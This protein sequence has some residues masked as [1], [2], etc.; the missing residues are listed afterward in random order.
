[1]LGALRTILLLASLCLTSC[2][3]AKRAETEQIEQQAIQPRADQVLFFERPLTLAA[4]RKSD[5]PSPLVVLLD[6]DP[7]AAVIGSDSPTFA[8]YED[9]TVIQRT[10]TGFITARLTDK[11][12]RQL[13]D[14]LDL[15]ALSQ[16]Y[17]RFEAEVATD[18]PEQD[19]LAYWGE[20][21]VFVSVYGSLKDD[22]VRSKMPQEVNAAYDVLSSF[23][24][25]ESRAWLP[26]SVEVMIWPYENAPEPSISWPEDWPRLD[27]PQNVRRGGNSF[28]IF[29][30]SQKL[31]E[32]RAFLKRKSEKGA[33]EIDGQKWSAAIRFPFPHEKLWMAPHPELK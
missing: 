16:S 23:K 17:G 26:A 30:P 9:G 29:M 31:P 2:S 10:T 6:S 11:E 24:H 33:I 15:R 7:W 13:L 5:V 12:V 21:P 18:Q 8:L 22:K 19:L 25:L 32:L 14:R 28:S 4:A 27:D 20:K 3:T 1:M